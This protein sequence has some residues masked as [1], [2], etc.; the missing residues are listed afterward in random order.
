[1]TDLQHAVAAAIADARSAGL[2]QAQQ[3]QAAAQAVM[4]LRP[5]LQEHE[6]RQLV[7]WLPELTSQRPG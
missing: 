5:Y 1:M 7:R 3:M 2:D 4:R 6:A